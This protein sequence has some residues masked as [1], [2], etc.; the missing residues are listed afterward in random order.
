MK[1][2]TSYGG[3]PT[4]F[5]TGAK[6][7]VVYVLGSYP[8][9]RARQVGE[10]FCSPQEE[11]IVANLE[12]EGVERKECRFGYVLWVEPAV[13]DNIFSVSKYN[14]SVQHFYSA[15]MEDIRE[16]RPKIIL[17]IGEEALKF[18]C[19]LSQLDKFRGS[20]L[21]YQ[22]DKDIRVIPTYRVEDVQQG[23]FPLMLAIRSDCRK[24]CKLARGL[25][26]FRDRKFLNVARGAKFRDFR[27]E[28]IRLRDIEGFLAYD[29]EGW[30]PKLDCISFSDDPDRAVSVPLNMHFPEADTIDLFRL[31]NDVLQ[32][33]KSFKIAH[34]ML[35]DNSVLRKY[36]IG[37]RNVFMDTMVAHHT[38]FTE[39]GNKFPHSLAFC[40]SIYTWEKYYKD[41]RQMQGLVSN[42]L[43]ADDY[44][45]KDSAVTLELVPALMRE[46][47]QYG[48][49]RY[50][51]DIMMPKIKSAA[52]MQ[53]HGL[54]LD[55]KA[56]DEIRGKTL[57]SLNEIKEWL[58]IHWGVEPSKERQVKKL[59]YEELKLPKRFNAVKDK[60]YGG[61]KKSLTTDKEALTYLI[62]RFPIHKELLSNIIKANQLQHDIGHYLDAI[63]E[64]GRLFYS[65]NVCGTSSGRYS[66]SKV[67]NKTGVAAHG[68][69][70][71]MRRIIIPPS[72]DTV[73]WACDAKQAESMYV[74]WVAKEQILFDA[75]MKGEDTHQII[76]SII[77]KLPSK[78][79]VDELRD[80]AKTIRHGTNYWMGAKTLQN[81][82]NF[83]FPL[84]D[85]TFQDA[86]NAI[87][88]IR[89]AN[90]QTYQWG[91][92][93]EDAIYSG[94]RLF[95]N[96]Y[97][98]QR[99]LIGPKS[100]DL[101][102]S[103]IS[104]DP[105][106]SIGDMVSIACS[107]VI[108]RFKEFNIEKN[109]VGLTKHDELLGICEEKNIE[110]VKEIVTEEME[111][112]LPGVEFNNIPLVILSTF[113]IG[114]NWRD[115]EKI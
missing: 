58:L 25:K 97:G 64:D 94:V 107:N 51:F 8:S 13:R 66:I 2:E 95:H 73:I 109:Y 27:D 23:R 34:N 46:L 67:I 74:T 81:R 47:N 31:V 101:V 43:E 28:L 75:F 108:E 60:K 71:P 41:D 20:P 112:P 42:R 111:R 52:E 55:K 85:F 33:V 5:P 65:V 84:F 35:F 69:P 103:A 57:D 115:L 87:K 48:L 88:A 91:K 104:F 7:P 30:Y 44:S 90:P 14:I 19:G 4:V 96:C 86:K 1:V 39:S 24:V 89:K 68:I 26:P 17:A 53:R 6:Y 63:D 22:F 18:T 61:K 16:H 113:V 70:I 93:I 100:Q 32:N 37:V 77:F 9:T 15:V 11:I 105:Q 114:K 98:R 45:C 36:G 12:R 82:V 99:M 56:R 110:K 76:G 38:V 40:T 79:I 3:R 21:K 49:T 54:V 59:L 106:S 29:I 92:R 62:Q 83:K 50:F 78:E 102:R 10:A 72:D 80:V